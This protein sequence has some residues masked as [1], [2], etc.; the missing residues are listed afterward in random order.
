MKLMKCVTMLLLGSVS[1]MILTAFSC[2]S[3]TT[4]NFTV[5]IEDVVLL[6]DG[7]TVQLGGVQGVA[8]SG[9]FIADLGSPV[10][11]T[12]SFFAGTDSSGNILVFSAR[13]PAQWEIDWGD[14]R[15]ANQVIDVVNINPGDFISYPCVDVQAAPFSAT[16]NPVNETN[17]L[18]MTLQG[19]GLDPTFGMPEVDFYNLNYAQKSAS[20]EAAC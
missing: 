14:P 4:S 9:H 7:S 5:H 8:V 17:L 13:I 11:S 16:P 10:G 19:S 2:N 6:N 12:T 18:P 20:S 15:C 1:L 3:G